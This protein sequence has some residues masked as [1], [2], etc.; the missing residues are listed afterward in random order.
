MSLAKAFV[1]EI[2]LSEDLASKV[3]IRRSDLDAVLGANTTTSFID[4]IGDF[5]T[6]TQSINFSLKQSNVSYSSPKSQYASFAAVI[7]DLKGNYEQLAEK[8]RTRIGT[9]YYIPYDTL[10][11]R[12]KDHLSLSEDLDYYCDLGAIVPGIIFHRG[13]LTR[14]CRTGEP[15]SDYNW[16]RTQ[17]L[18]PLALE[19]FRTVMGLHGSA[20]EPTVLNKLLS[21]FTY[22]YPSDSYHELHCLI[23]EPYTFGTL[24]HVYH[25]HRAPST[26]SIYK[27]ERI[28]P[29]YE[30]DEKKKVFLGRKQAHM[31]K[32][33]KNVFDERGEV[34]FPEIV[35]YFKLLSQIYKHFRNVDVLNML[36]ICREQNYFYAHVLYNVRKATEDLGLYIDNHGTRPGLDALQNSRENANSAWTKLRLA[37]DLPKTL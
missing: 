8:K 19:Q 7:D 23:G 17:V 35:T 34:P 30:W 13:K 15:E 18:I 26:P 33:I 24:V 6:S 32:E 28:S 10:F 9:H 31:I 21:N 37:N 16:K 20:V 5:I 14:G 1:Q 27:S 25:R 4:G 3:V 2:L 22:D 12:F 29:Y 11:R 36:S